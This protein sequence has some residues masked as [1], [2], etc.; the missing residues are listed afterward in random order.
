MARTYRLLVLATCI[1]TV[2]TTWTAPAHAGS[3]VYTNIIIPKEFNPY[4][5]SVNDKN[6]VAGTATNAKG[7]DPKG[8]I[9]TP[10][11]I[12]VSQDG[13]VSFKTINDRQF[14]L[15]LLV[16]QTSVDGQYQIYNIKNQVSHPISV[17]AN[18]YMFVLG[19]N[20][21]NTI[22]G[23][24]DHKS[25]GVIDNFIQH[26]LQRT[27]FHPPGVIDSQALYINDSGL[28]LGQ[29]EPTKGGTTKDFLYQN[30]VFAYPEI[31]HP[32]YQYPVFLAN[33]GTIGGI[34]KTDP[35]YHGFTWRKGVF[36]TYDYPGALV[37]TYLV[38]PGPA[39]AL[40]GIYGPVGQT[41]SFVYRAGTYYTLKGP[42]GVAIHITG[43]SPTKGNL[44]GNYTDSAGTVHA[45]FATCPTNQAPCTQ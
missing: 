45:F 31:A 29:Y 24:V 7:H 17:A 8:F 9:W 41:Q 18:E 5:F 11:K 3:Y 1:L 14:A 12:T 19:M 33:D 15:G 25:T 4:P 20:V 22:F 37:G 43:V 13:I 34:Y 21:T 36:T 42:D 10:V 27:Y 35:G 32:E 40:Y 6:E 44:V 26:G 28:V 39:G 16:S 38:G 23:Y 2:Q 30:G